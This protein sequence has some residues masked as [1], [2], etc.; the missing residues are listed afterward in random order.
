MAEKDSVK[1]TESPTEDEPESVGI[2]PRCARCILAELKN[3]EMRI[4]RL[5]ETM[6]RQAPATED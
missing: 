5:A 2:D 3:L 4:D 1:M 6:G